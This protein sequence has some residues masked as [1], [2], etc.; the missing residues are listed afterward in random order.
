VK[1]VLQKG[2][3]IPFTEKPGANEKRNNKT[4]RDKIEDFKSIVEKMIEQ[5]VV[6]V[7]K[8]KPTCL[9]PLGLVKRV[10]ED[11]SVK[12]RLIWDASRHVNTVIKDQHIRL[13]HLN[14]AF[15]I[16]QPGDC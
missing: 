7:G 11:R 2:Y 3:L 1:G 5:G 14:R 4:A 8:K 16:T 9:S 15:K 10:Q 13:A 6:R 12:Q